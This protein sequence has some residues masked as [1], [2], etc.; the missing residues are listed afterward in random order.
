MKFIDS[1][2][3]NE[4]KVMPLCAEKILFEL[5]LELSCDDVNITKI[6]QDF[7]KLKGRTAEE[8]PKMN[9]SYEI[10]HIF[11][12][13]KTFLSQNDKSGFN[14]IIQKL[15][16]LHCLLRDLNIPKLIR[17][18][19]ENNDAL[20]MVSDKNIFLFMGFTGSGKHSSFKIF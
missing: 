10:D 5:I 11:R 12:D 7:E 14:S 1:D 2:D 8:N 15:K 17:L 20:D 16:E 4:L 19:K 13:M 9:H 6:K 3:L 18:I